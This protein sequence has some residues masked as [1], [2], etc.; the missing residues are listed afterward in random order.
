MDTKDA[1]ALCFLNRLPVEE[2]A[3]LEAMFTLTWGRE[4]ANLM[5]GRAPVQV[6]TSQAGEVFADMSLEEINAL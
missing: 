1:A 6:S 2:R 3:V 5:A 4:F